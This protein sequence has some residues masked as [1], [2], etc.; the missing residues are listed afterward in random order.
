MN[1][2]STWEDA[3]RQAPDVPTYRTGLIRTLIQMNELEAAS[4]ATQ[5]AKKHFPE[6]QSFDSYGS[7]IEALLENRE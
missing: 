7:Q 6:V 4:L 5:A 1:P 2:F 3:I